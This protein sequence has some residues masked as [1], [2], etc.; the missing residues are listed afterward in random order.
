MARMMER[1]IGILTPRRKQILDLVV[2]EYIKAAAPV[3]SKAICKYPGLNVS[4]ATVRNE[5]AYLEEYGYLTHPHTSAGRVPTERGY[6]YF[7]E[8]LMDDMRLPVE[9][10]RMIVH[11]FHQT[12]LDINQW[13]RLAATVLAHASRGAAVVAPP[14]VYRCQFKHVELISTHGALVL[15]VLVLQGGLVK[16]QV[17]T[18]SEAHSQADLSRICRWLNDLFAGND[19]DEIR[20]Q[21]AALPRFEQEIGMMVAQIMAQID[22]QK[23]PLYRDGLIN[24]LAQPEFEQNAN[25]VI[26]VFSAGGPLDVA[27]A[28]LLSRGMD[29]QSVQVV[30]GGEGQYSDLADFSLV[31]SRYGINNHITGA[32]GVL[33]PIRMPYARTVSAVRFVSRL[34]SSLIYDTYGDELPIAPASDHTNREAFK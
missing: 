31:L 22:Q 10:Q 26:H 32:L 3:G 20:Q 25:H 17:L 11:Q 19:A 24:V 16:Q 29:S 5:M 14:R 9:E 1:E 15:L 4:P 6:R 8:Q 7:V 30:I 2:R 21:L 28:D 18:L 33:G 13:M 27:L 12:Q 23:E 34:L